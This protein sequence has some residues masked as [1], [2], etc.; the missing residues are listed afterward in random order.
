[1]VDDQGQLVSTQ[2]T[3]VTFNVVSGPGYI[4]GVG[5]GDPAAHNAQQ[6][7][8]AQT[9]AGTVK[10]AV[11]VNVDCVSPG[12]QLAGTIDIDK[13]TSIVP[14]DCSAY[15]KP[16]VVEATNGKWTTMISIPVSADVATHGYLAVASA[17]ATNLTDY[18]YLKEFRG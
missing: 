17:T 12:R 1:M 13:T 7:K 2:P 16:I 14:G 5:S 8:T 15:T 4:L 18:T 11:R 10:A 3:E 9:F 6:G